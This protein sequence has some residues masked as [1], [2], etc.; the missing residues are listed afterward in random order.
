MDYSLPDSTVHGIFQARVL[1]WGAIDF[2]T[3]HHKLNQSW[4]SIKDALLVVT[5]LQE[6]IQMALDTYYMAI[7]L[8][9]AIFFIQIMKD[10]K[11][12]WPWGE[13]DNN[14]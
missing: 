3:D 12:S 4:A 6:Q 13:M 9:N 10:R 14:T 11:N 1:E 7:D 2:S 8:I 5:S